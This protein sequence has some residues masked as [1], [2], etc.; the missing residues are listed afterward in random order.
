MSEYDFTQLQFV[1]CDIVTQISPFF[2]T[3]STIKETKEQHYLT[4]IVYFQVQ[5]PFCQTLDDELRDSGS[6]CLI[7]VWR[8]EC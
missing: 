2:I 6:S 7:D 4:L 5:C 1:P 3:S 8:E